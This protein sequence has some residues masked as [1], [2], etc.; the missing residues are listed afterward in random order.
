[1]DLNQSQMIWCVLSVSVRSILVLGVGTGLSTISLLFFGVGTGLYPSLNSS[2][3]EM[4]LSLYSCTICLTLPRGFGIGLF[5]VE[6]SLSSAV[7]SLSLTI[8]LI[9][10]LGVDSTLCFSS[11]INFDLLSF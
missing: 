7:M 4:M 9:L 3:G 11:L 2:G 10:G 6:N 8:C 5:V 1:M